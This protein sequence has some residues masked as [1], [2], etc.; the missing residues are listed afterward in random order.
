MI[1][2]NDLISVSEA[3]FKKKT[4]AC[5]SVTDFAYLMYE[6]QA[7]DL[8]AA[9]SEILSTAKGT[10]FYVLTVAGAY[11]VPVEKSSEGQGKGTGASAFMTEV[12]MSE[13][14]PEY[15]KN[16]ELPQTLLKEIK[17]K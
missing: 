13:E 8:P 9:V 4:S 5:C 1:R 12:S 16:I 17:K 6:F 10:T 14:K 3:C 2:A 11:G 7:K 15:L